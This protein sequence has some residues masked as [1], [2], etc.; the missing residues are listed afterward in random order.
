MH[1][2]PG[3]ALTLIWHMHGAV[4]SPWSACQLSSTLPFILEIAL[5]L[6]PLNF[7]RGYCREDSAGPVR[8]SSIAASDFSPPQ[9][10]ASVRRLCEDTRDDNGKLILQE[11]EEN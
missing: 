7:G 4:C 11:S 5:Q 3:K 9:F 1:R 2:S 8:F 10:A 6:L